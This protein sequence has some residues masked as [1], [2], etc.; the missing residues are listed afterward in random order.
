MWSR[1]MSNRW[2]GALGVEV[3]DRHDELVLV[4][5]RSG[6][7]A[8]DDPAEEAVSAH[9]GPPPGM[10]QCAGAPAWGANGMPC[11][12]TAPASRVG[13]SVPLGLGTT[14]TT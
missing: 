2:T 11:G 12:F 13:R 1:G 8:G 14:A 9:E 6:D 10:G 5:L 3:T 4:D 7:L